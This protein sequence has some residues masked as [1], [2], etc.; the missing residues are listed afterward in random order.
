MNARG[1]VRAERAMAACPEGLYPV[2]EGLRA[3]V[4]H[5]PTTWTGVVFRREVL[6]VVGTLDLEVGAGSDVDLLF[7]AAVRFPFVLRHVP[8]AVFVPDS[9]ADIPSWRGRV[10]GFWPGWGRMVDRLASDPSLPTE[11]QEEVR[12]VLT[13]R[14]RHYMGLVSAA[15][16]VR[17]DFGQARLAADLLE[18]ELGRPGRARLLRA[19]A[20]AC[21]GVPG[22]HRGLRGAFALRQW[23]RH[24][25][26][27]ARRRARYDDLPLSPSGSAG[28]LPGTP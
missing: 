13:A 3:L 21:A 16:L 9:I 6:D 22:A 8:G 7:R 17:G 27:A 11:V 24:A 28:S 18:R 4:R 5:V 1:D 2:P 26:H 25:V 19:A 23:L 12:S 20:S 15:A 10:E 14:L